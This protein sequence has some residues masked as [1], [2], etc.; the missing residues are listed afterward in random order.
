MNRF[1][2]KCKIIGTQFIKQQ[3]DEG[4]LLLREIPLSPQE[5][6]IRKGCSFC[7]CDPGSHV[8]SVASLYESAPSGRARIPLSAKK[9]SSFAWRFFFWRWK[10]YHLRLRR[11]HLKKQ[12]KLFCIRSNGLL[13]ISQ[14]ILKL[15]AKV[16]I[17]PHFFVFLHSLLTNVDSCHDSTNH[18]SML[19]LAAPRIFD[20]LWIKIEKWK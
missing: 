14:N 7:V 8:L 2:G 17:I 3:I 5:R 9:T 6:A 15:L 10:D 1:D 20:T 13:V 11:C 12:N 18:A 16:W 19:V 4:H